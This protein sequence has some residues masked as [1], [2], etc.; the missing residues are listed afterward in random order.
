MHFKTLEEL[1][2]DDHPVHLLESK[3][4]SPRPLHHFAPDWREC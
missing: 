2:Q 3:K 1:G 4:K